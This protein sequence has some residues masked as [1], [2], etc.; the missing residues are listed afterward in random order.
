MFFIKFYQDVNVTLLIELRSQDRPKKSK[1]DD[2]ILSTKT[3][4]LVFV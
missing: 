4:N 3:L 2:V 1:V